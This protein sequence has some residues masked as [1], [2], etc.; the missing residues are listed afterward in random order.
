MPSY[1]IALLFHAPALIEADIS[2]FD[3]YRRTLPFAQ[4]YLYTNDISDEIKTALQK[5]DVIIRQDDCSNHFRLMRRMFTEVDA[6]VFAV[7]TPLMANA[8]D[9]ASMVHQLVEQRKDMIIAT[10]TPLGEVEADYQRMCTALYGHTLTTPLSPWRVFSRRFVKS[11]AA[12]ERG[13]PV[14]LEWSIHALELDIPIK[15]HAATWPKKTTSVERRSTRH[16]LTRLI[17]NLQARPMKW[18]GVITL[19]S[20]IG[21]ATYKILLLL[22]LAGYS[23]PLSFTHAALGAGIMAILTFIS[24]LSGL[25]VHSISYQRRELKRLHFQQHSTL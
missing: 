25:A 23:V 9:T 24:A 11:F 10:G 14:E 16:S 20:A 7:I 18:F 3:E 6:D 8:Q 5:R 13:F 4:I 17:L 12:F 15:E 2:T 22:I 21:C 19:L 1:S